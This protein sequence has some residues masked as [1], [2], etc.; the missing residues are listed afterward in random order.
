MPRE[1]R[2][3][4]GGRC[5]HVAPR[6]CTERESPFAGAA[7]SYGAQNDHNQR[8]TACA[9]S[10]V[11]CF[12]TSR[13]TAIAVSLLR[14]QCDS[15]LRVGSHS[16]NVAPRSCIIGGERC[17]AGAVP[18]QGTYADRSQ[19]GAARARA[20]LVC[21]A[22]S[23]EKVSAVAGPPVGHAN[24]DSPLEATA[25]TS[26]HGLAP[27]ERSLPPVQCPLTMRR[28]IPTSAA[29]RARVARSRVLPPPERQPAQ[30]RLFACHVNAGYEPDATACTSHHGL[31]PKK[32]GLLPW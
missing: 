10:N 30:W 28:T 19:R 8:S 27:M 5:S 6:S 31:A 16:S 24:V 14:V 7:L 26:H 13:E 9:R 22:A 29:R 18:F 25:R 3:R 12:A 15:R 23:R 4:V 11:S 1:C 17:S 21:F 2:L 32:K 20:K